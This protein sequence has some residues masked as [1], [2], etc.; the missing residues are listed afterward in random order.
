MVGQ[1]ELSRKKKLNLKQLYSSGVSSDLSRALFFP[2]QTG[3][4]R[5]LPDPLLKLTV[6]YPIPT[7]FIIHLLT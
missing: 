4:G 2:V 3:Q 1:T 5:V 6:I 7:L